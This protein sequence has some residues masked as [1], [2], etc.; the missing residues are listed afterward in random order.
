MEDKKKS[1]WCLIEIITKHFGFYIGSC[2][3]ADFGLNICLGVRQNKK[4]LE[5]HE[6]SYRF[7]FNRLW[8]PRYLR[9]K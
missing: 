8:C 9:T 6:S 1:G 4:R 7:T 3:G 5:W 2:R